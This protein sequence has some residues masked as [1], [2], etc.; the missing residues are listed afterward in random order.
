[1][2]IQEESLARQS[3]AY[4]TPAISHHD[5]TKLIVRRKSCRYGSDQGH[6]VFAI[7]WTGMLIDKVYL[8]VRFPC[9]RQHIYFMQPVTGCNQVASGIKSIKFSH[10]GIIFFQAVS[11]THLR[12]HETRHDLVCRL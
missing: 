2:M 3:G 12:A 11:Y 9:I 6:D 8:P 7:Q 1:M 4:L 10:K 5:G